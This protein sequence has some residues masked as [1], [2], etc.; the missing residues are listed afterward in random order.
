M[1][2][3]Y[4]LTPAGKTVLANADDVPF[5]ALGLDREVVIGKLKTLEEGPV[6]LPA[7]DERYD[8]VEVQ[9]F[10]ECDIA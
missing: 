10:V 1:T 3:E 8:D 7:D 4:T 9:G 6:T 2:I 5:E